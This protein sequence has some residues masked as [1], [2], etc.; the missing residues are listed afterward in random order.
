M[1]ARQIATIFALTAF[2]ATL[3]AGLAAGNAAGA[4]LV[5]SIALMLACYAVGRAV[6][7]AIQWLM[8]S[9]IRRFQA[10]NPPA[11][12]DHELPQDSTGSDE[13]ADA[14]EQG[15]VIGAVN[16]QSAQPEEP[17]QSTARRAA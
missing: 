15:R 13:P 3:L 11:A 16:P 1:Q 8:R 10:A 5:R 9:E 14:S 6:G 7:A 12:L 2:A 4:A 17:L